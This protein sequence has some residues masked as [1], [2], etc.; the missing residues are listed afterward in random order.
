MANSKLE[1]TIYRCPDCNNKLAP[2]QEECEYC[3]SMLSWNRKKSGLHVRIDIRDDR[4]E[5]VDS[6]SGKPIAYI[7]G[8]NGNVLKTLGICIDALVS[9]EQTMQATEMRSRVF[10]STSWDDAISIMNEYVVLA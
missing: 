10:D 7:T 1:V 5:T 2:E 8:E 3:G 6:G 9:V 4:T